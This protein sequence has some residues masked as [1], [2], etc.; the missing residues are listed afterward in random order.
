MNLT[1]R[2]TDFREDGVF[3]VL[4]DEKG[5]QIAV[6][7]EHACDSGLGNGSYAP[8]LPPGKYECK[9]G[10]HKLHNNIPFETFEVLDVPGH[11]GILLHVGN[12][13]KDSDGCIL[14]GRGYGG[15][16]RMI[17]NSRMT[18]AAFMGLQLGLTKFILTVTNGKQ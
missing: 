7:L 10:I 1:L 8:K 17:S 2:R 12:Y 6:T 15:D 18:F 3:G 16:P 4:L 14:L 13:N 5:K 11:K 9:R